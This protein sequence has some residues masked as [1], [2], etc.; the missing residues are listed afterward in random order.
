MEYPNTTILRHPLIQH[1][2]TLV[3]DRR[4]GTRDVRAL[5][6]EISMLMAYEATRDLFTEDV[7]I[8]TPLEPTRGFALAGQKLVL[9]P[10]LRAGLG[11]LSGVQDLIPSARVGHIGLERDEETLEVRSYYFKMPNNV[12]AR[13]ILILDPMLATG[14]SA[15]AAVSAVQEIGAAD[16]RVLCLVAAPE[17]IQQLTSSHPGVRIIAAAVDRGLNDKGYIVPGLG[18]AGDRL[19]GTK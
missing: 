19:F 11:M 13:Q 17:G 12:E 16:I 1:K 9:V 10:V 3:R 4:T 14:N 2:L 18:D 15:V 7:E 8:E 6:R 5:V